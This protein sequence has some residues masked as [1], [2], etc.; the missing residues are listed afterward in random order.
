MFLFIFITLGVIILVALGVFASKSQ[1]SNTPSNNTPSTKPCDCSK[2]PSADKSFYIKNY[3]DPSTSVENEDNTTF[4][5]NW[6]N[7]LGASYT[8]ANCCC[9]TQCNPTHDL[10][11][12]VDQNCQIKCKGY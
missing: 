5:T 8:C 9:M 3:S 2:I 10:T 1:S 7:G 11:G 4:C 12:T 6:I